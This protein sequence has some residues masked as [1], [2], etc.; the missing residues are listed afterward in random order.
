MFRRKSIVPSLLLV[1]GSLPAL[2][3]VPAGWQKQAPAA[4]NAHP[5]APPG[6]SSFNGHAASGPSSFSGSPQSNVPSSGFH[7]NGPGPHK[8]DWLRKYFSLPPNQ[9]EQKLQQDPAYRTLPPSGQQHLLDRLRQ[10]NSE[11][12]QK[13]QQILNRMETY[14]HMTPEQQKTAQSLFQR[15]HALPED[16]RARVSQEYRRLRGM[17]PEQRAQLMNSDEF[18]NNFNEDERDLL[19]GMT[20]L[21]VGPNRTE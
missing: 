7:F 16:R 8:G 17:P 1:L 19:H 2:A 6:S 4:N 5:A 10:F 11:P 18:R 15:Y 20:D 13:K 14:E 21:N 9:Q 12:P 3:L